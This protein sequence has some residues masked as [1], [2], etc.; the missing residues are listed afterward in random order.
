MQSSTPLKY[1][2]QRVDE[3]N[4]PHLRACQILGNFVTNSSDRINVVAATTGHF[5]VIFG[6]SR[7]F[8]IFDSVP[9]SKETRLTQETEKLVQKCLSEELGSQDVFP[10]PSD[11]ILMVGLEA[12][13]L[14]LQFFEVPGASTK[15]QHLMCVQNNGDINLWAWDTKLWQ[16]KHSGSA[17]LASGPGSSPLLTHAMVVSSTTNRSVEVLWTEQGS[18]LPKSRTIRWALNVQLSDSVF[19][20]AI[21]CTTAIPTGCSIYHGDFGVWFISP[22]K[23]NMWFWFLQNNTTI[24]VNHEVSSSVCFCIVHPISTELI[25]CYTN[26]EVYIYSQIKSQDSLTSGVMCVLKPWK[27]NGI[28]HVDVMHHFIVIYYQEYASIYE[29]RSGVLVGIADLPFDVARMP[30]T[31]WHRASR[32]DCPLG[33]WNSKG[34]WQLWSPSILVVAQ[35]LQ[36][37]SPTNTVHSARLCKAWGLHYWHAKYLLDIIAIYAQSSDKDERQLPHVMTAS[38]E[39]SPYLQNPGLITGLLSR[40]PPFQAYSESALTAFV[41][42]L[43]GSSEADGCIAFHLFTPLNL[44]LSPLFESYIS[45]KPQ[46]DGS[47]DY[48]LSDS[49]PG[50][51]PNVLE[52]DHKRVHL[53]LQHQ[54]QQMMIKLKSAVGLSDDLLIATNK[55]RS[56]AS[57]LCSSLSVVLFAGE[58]VL[59]GFGT[60][61]SQQRKLNFIPYFQIL[62]NLLYEYEP[63]N[64]L[65]FIWLV[66]EGSTKHV[67]KYE[68]S[69]YR[70]ALDCLPPLLC[71][72][73]NPSSDTAGS[74]APQKSVCHRDSF[75]SR[76]TTHV[77]LLLQVGEYSNA[78]KLLLVVSHKLTSFGTGIE[79]QNKYWSMALELVAERADQSVLH[80]ELFSSLLQ[81]CLS[82][83]NQSRALNDIWKLAP[84]NLKPSDLISLVEVISTPQPTNNSPFVETKPN[85]LAGPN[86]IPLSVF[87]PHLLAML[88]AQKSNKK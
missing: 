19:G 2:F 21:E 52:L 1:R 65:S 29:S 11:G 16:W 5:A 20:P 39:L 87:K 10:L 49:T 17:R 61:A 37:Q 67:K 8:V 12:P 6:K 84:K 51:E 72:R 73:F 30:I 44:S 83:P 50:V 64:L 53:Y 25:V 34:L 48:R 41:A 85:V 18:D 79:R 77:E 36:T 26:G 58:E 56:L 80:N 70:R 55:D 62:A 13:I 57:E 38:K 9:T 54:P 66:Q 46:A 82:S 88:R 42:A 76:V 33:F 23:K 15:Q 40:M 32:G 75:H 43:K 3:G 78:L 47:R 22:D 4:W 7:G 69:F 68:R 63:Q 81:F 59:P 28:Q 71:D 60:A 45:E 31:L 74:L 24:R 27:A 35:Y 86:G 14:L